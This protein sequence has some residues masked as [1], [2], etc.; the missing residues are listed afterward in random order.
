MPDTQRSSITGAK[1]LAKLRKADLANATLHLFKEGF[2]P[3]VNSSLAEFAAQEADYTTYAAKSIAAWND[4]SLASVSGYILTAQLQSF[5]LAAT[6]AAPNVIGGWYLVHSDGTTLIDFGQFDP[7][8]PM[9]VADQTIQ[10]V[11]TEL[12]PAGV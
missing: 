5:L 9:Q 6:P 11:P 1:N 8:R 3:S 12:F 2:V 10:I 7:P 4:P